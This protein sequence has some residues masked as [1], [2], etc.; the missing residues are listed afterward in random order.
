LIKLQQANIFNIFH[1]GTIT[2]LCHIN[3]DI[4]LTIE[5]AYLAELINS[6]FRFFKV[7]LI[8]C[9]KCIFELWAEESQIIDNLDKIKNLELEILEAKLEDYLLKVVCAHEI[10]PGGILTISTEDI[11]VYDESYQAISYEEL[12]RICGLYWKRT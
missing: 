7:R 1:D 6:S 11:L 3:N 2:E 10:E 4:E 9:E 12:D 5:I 8:K